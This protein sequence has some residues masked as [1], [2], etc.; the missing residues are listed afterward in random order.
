MLQ[1]TRGGLDKYIMRESMPPL[2]DHQC[3][4]D[5][6]GAKRERMRSEDAKI[7]ATPRVVHPETENQPQ[8]D[9]LS[10]QNVPAVSPINRFVSNPRLIS[11]TASIPSFNLKPR[12]GTVTGI[13][14]HIHHQPP[15]VA[16]LWSRSN[17]LASLN[18]D[19]SPRIVRAFFPHLHFLLRQWRC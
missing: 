5:T 19:K 10:T 13:H 12:A 14:E 4:D 2:C 3:K 1:K 18:R 11:T 16:P 7:L 17:S 8:F 6:G 9:S 15:K